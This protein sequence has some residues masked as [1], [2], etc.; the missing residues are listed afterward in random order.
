MH[1][2]Y[3]IRPV[4]LFLPTLFD[5]EP[6]EVWF[7]GRALP[8]TLAPSFASL[9]FPWVHARSRKMM[10]EREVPNDRS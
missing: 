7:S 4:F 5:E 6:L 3:H 9:S 8:H 10:G 1:T 2:L